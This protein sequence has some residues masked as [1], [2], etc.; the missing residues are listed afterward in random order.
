MAHHPATRE[1]R[2]QALIVWGKFV[3]LSLDFLMH[4][5]RRSR[6]NDGVRKLDV[7]PGRARP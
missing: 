1:L 2:N 6:R 7:E 5:L 4:A 3:D